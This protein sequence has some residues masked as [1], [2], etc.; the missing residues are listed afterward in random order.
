MIGQIA[1]QSSS[2]QMVN[3]EFRVKVKR[4]PHID[5]VMGLKKKISC[6][7]VALTNRKLLGFKVTS[8]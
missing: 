6:E 7:F 3:W 2:L 4:F 8:V 1:S 5:L